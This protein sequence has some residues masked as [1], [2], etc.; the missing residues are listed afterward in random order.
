MTWIEPFHDR[1]CPE[2]TTGLEMALA[3]SLRVQ[4]AASDASCETPV[5]VALKSEEAL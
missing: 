2:R 5:A 3:S 1:G 4:T